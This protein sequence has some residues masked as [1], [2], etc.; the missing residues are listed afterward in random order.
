MEELQRLLALVLNE[1]L[2]QVILSN[3]RDAAVAT[4]AKIRPVL[5]GENLKFQE[6]RYQGTKVFHENYSAEEMAQRIEQE[7]TE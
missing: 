3:S 4:K 1:N 7:L 5:I 6:T 2:E